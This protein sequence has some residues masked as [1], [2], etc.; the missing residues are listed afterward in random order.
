MRATFG[1]LPLLRLASLRGPRSGRADVKRERGA[2]A[3]LGLDADDAVMT[4]HDLL[5][6]RK[7]HA[8][9]AAHALSAGVRA[10]EAAEDTGEVL[11]GDADARVS[12]DT[13][14]HV[15]PPGDTVTTT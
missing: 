7:P 6:Q 15:G 1:E 11:L 8:K 14:E 10:P 12:T 4:V 9:A 2:L 13:N 3:Q 5:G